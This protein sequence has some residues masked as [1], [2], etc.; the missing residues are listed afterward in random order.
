MTGER[1]P[2]RKRRG[3]P[4]K[5]IDLLGR[6][7]DSE[8]ARRAGVSRDTVMLERQWRG[9]EST[10]PH[11]APVEWTP[12]R[13]ALIGTASDSRLARTLGVSSDVVRRKRLMLGIPPFHPAH[14]N[15]SNPAY[16]WTPAD[17][18]LL[19]QQ[20]DP[21]MA[22]RL[23][24]H[25]NVVQQKRQEMGIPPFHQPHRLQW[26]AEM[27]E[28]LGKVPDKV[29]A[30]RFGVGLTT[31]YRKRLRRGIP[32]SR[33]TR[34][35]R[36]WPGS[37]ERA[38][39]SARAEP[40][41]GRP[42]REVSLPA[43]ANLER[44][45]ARPRLAWP[46]KLVSLLGRIPDQE[47]ARRAG[48]S[49]STVATERQRRGIEACYAKR[50]PIRWTPEMIERL[51]TASDR[52]VAEEL[53]I[54][55]SCVRRKRTLLGIPPFFPTQAHVRPR[56]AKWTRK[57]LALLGKVIDKELAR[58]M[59]VNYTTIN[60][61]RQ[62]LGIPPCRPPAHR[63]EWTEE[64]LA[65]LGKV[66]DSTVAGRYGISSFSVFR[67]RRELGIPPYLNNYSVVPT[68]ELKAL[69]HLPLPSL[70]LERRTGLH[71]STIR[72]LRTKMGITVG[73]PAQPLRRSALPRRSR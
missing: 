17:L 3:W 25:R 20:P 16:P 12:E 37:G 47:L 50:D 26:T 22:E 49:L 30:K 31:I 52:E 53:K 69:L 40:P 23:G 14:L 8:L 9:I 64:M 46:K 13:I 39:R 51:G 62:Q 68:P 43:T 34:A 55:R 41:A 72:S 27:L 45:P 35:S 58:R 44:T 5:W 63:I 29:F 59:K 61:K 65:L 10:Q 28:L 56:T 73:S 15:L 57:N 1:S 54:P 2:A 19:G 18:A 4:E 70:E 32:P 33:L 66:C 7:P 11:H 48:V 38:S 36:F 60:R 24:I 67:K 71:R 42:G 6:I 21:Q